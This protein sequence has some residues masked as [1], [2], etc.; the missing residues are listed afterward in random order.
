M[1]C[2][3]RLRPLKPGARFVT[4]LEEADLAPPEQ[5]GAAIR[6]GLRGHD[7]DGP[8][9][10]AVVTFAKA[11]REKLAEAVEEFARN[12]WSLT[13]VARAATHAKLLASAFSAPLIRLRLEKLR[14]GLHVAFISGVNDDPV[15]ALAARVQECFVLPSTD[16]AVQRQ[17]LASD[18]LA[19]K[20]GVATL[21]ELLKRY[22]HLT[23]L[24]PN[25]TAKSLATPVKMKLR[26]LKRYD[27]IAPVKKPQPAW[28]VGGVWWAVIL[29][30]I[31]L[32]R[33]AGTSS[34]PD[35]DYHRQRAVDG[36]PSLPLVP[37]NRAPEQM[38]QADPPMRE[39]DKVPSELLPKLQKSSE[40]AAKSLDKLEQFVPENG[41]AKKSSDK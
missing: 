12:Y 26:R 17:E 37:R 13:P 25:L 4:R 28:K 6:L 27:D 16:R 21:S 29:M 18:L 23:C 34:P 5:L 1:V 9:V 22:P 36:R 40:K 2:P 31:A 33:Y 19:D 8:P 24:E 11:R 38:R 10:R 35:N 14:A 15:W 32:L 41:T 3:S 20:G 39:P 30:F 7:A